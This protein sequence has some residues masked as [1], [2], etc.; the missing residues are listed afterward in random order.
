MVSNIL[1]AFPDIYDLLIAHTL[2]SPMEEAYLVYFS[3]SALLDAP[4][5]GTMVPTVHRFFE[6]RSHGLV[7]RL[8]LLLTALPKDYFT[9]YVS[10]SLILD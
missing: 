4:V 9:K 2:F 8:Q 1:A 3:V 7:A 6:R 10:V 5:E